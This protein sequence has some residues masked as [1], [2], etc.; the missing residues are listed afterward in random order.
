M[1]SWLS[2]L[3]GIS[4]GFIIDSQGRS[5]FLYLLKNKA[6]IYALM[7]L[8]LSIILNSFI[9]FRDF[10]FDILIHL[11]TYAYGL[12]ISLKYTGYIF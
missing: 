2:E 4:L 8:D 12:C 11:F 1:A 9:S 3:A 5:H 6:N 10:E 7:K